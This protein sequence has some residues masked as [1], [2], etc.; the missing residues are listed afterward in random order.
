MGYA[1]LL[2]RAAAEPKLRTPIHGEE[3]DKMHGRMA[4][5]GALSGMVQ[6]PQD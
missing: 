5:K 2:F 1:S 4:R 6:E 3:T